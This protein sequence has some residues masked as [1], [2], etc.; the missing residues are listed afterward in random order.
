LRSAVEREIEMRSSDSVGRKSDFDVVAE[1]AEEWRRST[2]D[3]NM[4]AP[5]AG[6]QRQWW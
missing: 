2:A 5:R 4:T 6:R 1:K 3:H